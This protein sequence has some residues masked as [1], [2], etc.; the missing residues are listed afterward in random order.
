MGRPVEKPRFKT[1]LTKQQLEALSKEGV[2]F[3]YFVNN[4]D[5]SL[6]NIAYDMSNESKV[7]DTLTALNN[8]QLS[9]LKQKESPS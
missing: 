9:W 5:K 6:Y 1:K 3:A 4:D 7:K 2:T 8:Q